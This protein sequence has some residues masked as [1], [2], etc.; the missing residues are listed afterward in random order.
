M[1]HSLFEKYIFDGFLGVLYTEEG[2]YSN[3]EI[4]GFL[5]IILFINSHLVLRSLE[6]P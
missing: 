2:N 1:F 6:D 4:I 3:L 5:A